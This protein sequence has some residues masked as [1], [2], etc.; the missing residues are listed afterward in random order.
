MHHATLDQWARGSSLLHRRDARVK[1]LVFTGYLVALGATG[2]LSSIRALGFAALAAAGIYL[3]KLPLGGVLVRAGVVLPFAGIFA[4]FS[5]LGGESGR[6]AALVVRSY[7]SAVGVLVLVGTTPLPALL[8]GLESLGMPRFL[9]LVVQ[10]LYRYLFLL[11]EQAQHMRLAAASRGWRGFGWR[12]DAAGF[13][14]AATAAA[15]LFLRSHARAQGVHRAMLARGFEGRLLTLA[16]PGLRA[17][18]LWF[19]TA[20]WAACTAVWWVNNI[21]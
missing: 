4:L 17:A 19:L 15:V 10:F 21:R 5:W 16:P 18:D 9:V 8:A 12:P 6:G 14:A 13:R 20:G 1:L 3:G 2:S 7:L 11:S